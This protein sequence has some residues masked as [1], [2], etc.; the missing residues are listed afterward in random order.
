[1]YHLSGLQLRSDLLTG[2]DLVIA[3]MVCFVEK[4]KQCHQV[5][6]YL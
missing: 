5:H 6:T 3:W 4:T 2:T 1:M